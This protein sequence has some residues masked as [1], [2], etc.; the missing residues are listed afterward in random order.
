MFRNRDFDLEQKL[1]AN[2]S[3][4]IQDLELN[5]LFEAMAQGNKFLFSVA[6]V[7][8][9]TSL[10]DPDEIVYRQEI[11]TDC[12]ENPEVIREM[13]SI[14]VEAIQGEKETFSFSFRYRSPNS[15]LYSSVKKLELFVGVLKKLKN[16]ADLHA[17]KFRSQGF[18]RFF[19]MLKQEL[20]DDYSQV[21]EDCLQELEFKNGVLISA[22]LGRANKGVNYV[23]RKQTRQ[24]PS[25]IGRRVFKKK[26]N[27]KSEFSFEIDPRDE[28]GHQ[29]LSEL[30]ERGINL[31]A[32]AAAQAVD[33]ILSFFEVLHTE[34][35]FYTGCLNLH[36]IL[37]QG[38]EPT[39]IP[40]ALPKE[41]HSFSARELYDPCLSLRLKAKVVGNN[42]LADDKELIIITGA[43]QGG[44][45]TFLRSIGL[46]YLMMQCGMFAPAEHFSASVIEGVFT[47]F[48]REE[49]T[50]MKSGKLDEELK[51][52]SEIVDHITPRC[53][54]LCNE[55][56]SSTNE[57]EGSEI[58]RQV[59]GAMLDSGIK[60]FFVTFLFDFA[61]RIYEQ[62]NED[63][64]FL[65]AE[66]KADGSRTFRIV[67]GEPTPTAFGEDLY[68][69]IFDLQKAS[70]VT[71]P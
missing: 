46:G 47:H 13:Y 9:L 43:N 21:V 40:V 52:M 42:I 63:V 51:R 6:K 5:T 25:W 19:S 58:A 11:L 34:L 54:L 57:K 17:S 61:L 35:G 32:N 44:K 8:V 15:V 16:I 53:V 66:R 49:D 65:R 23:L 68:K 56:F 18:V 71:P 12:L 26:T 4:L 39:C 14:S 28:S 69:Q 2:A 37:E 50:T 10:T 60:V 1:P 64:L 59:L 38:C 24:R 29:S 62:R 45:S 27:G 7:G 3:D 20:D 41:K 22:Q 55:S 33:H 30:R 36:D 70:S 67:E 48:K 31:V